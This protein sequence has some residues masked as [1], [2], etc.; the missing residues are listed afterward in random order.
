MNWSFEPSQTSVFT[1]QDKV[2]HTQGHRPACA[3]SG[4]YWPPFPRNNGFLP[5]VHACLAFKLPPSFKCVLT[6]TAQIVQ[7]IPTFLNWTEPTWRTSISI[8]WSHSRGDQMADYKEHQTGNYPKA[9]SKESIQLPLLSFIMWTRSLAVGEVKYPLL[10]VF[11]RLISED[12]SVA[13]S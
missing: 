5:R 7:Y 9:S 1:L 10:Y 11:V 12:R 4:A 3:S 6:Q 2:T 8:T 13:F